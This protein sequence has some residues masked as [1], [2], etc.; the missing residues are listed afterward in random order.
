M[1]DEI[2]ALVTRAEESDDALRD[3]LARIADMPIRTR[4]EAALVCRLVASFVDRPHLHAGPEEG[5]RSPLHDVIAVF[6]QPAVRDAA[7][8]MR[9]WGLGALRRLYDEQLARYRERGPVSPWDRL[10]NDLLFALKVFASYGGPE[11]YQR[12]EA[13]ARL[14]LEP[15]GFLWSVVIQALDEDD[16]VRLFDALRDPIPPGFLAVALLDRAN[17]LARADRLDAHPF[18]TDE[19][20][21][22]LAALIADKD[23]ESW[24]H[25][26]TAAI[27]FL[28]AGVRDRLLAAARE[29]PAVNVRLEAAWAQ[30][31]LGDE[32]GVHLLAAWARDPR[33]SRRAVAYLEELGRADEIPI[34]AREPDFAAMAELCEWLAHPNEYG[35]PP[36]AVWVTDRRRIQWPPTRDERDVWLVRYAYGEGEGRT[37]GVGM[38]GSMTFAL[39]DEG[40]AALA[41]EDVYALHCCWELAMNHDERAPAERSVAE[42]RRLLGF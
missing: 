3:A 9:E 38:V 8:V 17:D 10:A 24:A 34:E 41:A 18:D 39:F 15:E 16:A 30:V 27:P 33:T 28:G 11:Q 6:Q 4:E 35:R 37:E 23:N 19:G 14:P 40:T 32:S 12:L 5:V 1:S 29:H 13:A 21:A 36:D 25:S 26:A 20:H 7:N 31:V 2:D 42:G 22:R